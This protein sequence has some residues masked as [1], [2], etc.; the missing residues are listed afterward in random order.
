MQEAGSWILESQLPS[1]QELRRTTPGQPG[2]KETAPSPRGHSTFLSFSGS[3]CPTCSNTPSGSVFTLR[4]LGL[5]SPTNWGQCIT[6]FTFAHSTLIIPTKLQGLG[7]PVNW[8]TLGQEFM[9]G[10]ICCE[11]GSMTRIEKEAL[12]WK[13]LLGHQDGMYPGF[14]LWVQRGQLCRC[15]K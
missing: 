2:T 12:N 8:V 4:L 10:L 15:V 13:F 9:P 14:Q 11:W 6:L 5:N 1:L 7:H 3:F